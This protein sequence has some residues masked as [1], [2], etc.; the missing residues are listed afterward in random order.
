VKFRNRYVAII[1]SSL[2]CITGCN[3]SEP[4]VIEPTGPQAPAPPTAQEIAQKII[5]EAQLDMDVPP[6][7]ARFPNT[8]R[9]NML[10]ILQSATTTNA[11]DPVGKE[12][13]VH[14]VGRIDK[15][16]RDFSQA[17][18]WQHVMVFT[19]AH[20]I[21]QPGSKKY[22]SLRAEAHTELSKPK[23]NVTGMPTIEGR[24][25]ILLSFYIPITD[26]SYKERVQVGDEIH[27]L[28]V[29]NIFGLDRGVTLEYLETGERFVAF[30]PGSL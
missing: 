11:A 15:R 30:L 16:I 29:I 8:M 24:Q 28:K 9:Q 5:L 2:L 1:F 6:P 12:A 22:A 17:E 19:D 27:G 3:S 25:L 20:A 26:K 23:V 13:L 21:F 10:N 4:E 14:V 18:A 7:G